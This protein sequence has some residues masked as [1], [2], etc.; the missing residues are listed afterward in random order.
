MAG[1]TVAIYDVQDYETPLRRAVDLLQQGGL[2]VLPTE[3][4]YGSAGILT[5]NPARERLKGLRNSAENKP[6]TIHVARAEDA[7]QYIAPPNE[8]AKR[9]MRKLWPGPVGIRFDVPGER[10]AEVAKNL[11]LVE[12]DLYDN[13]QITLRCPDHPV[14]EHVLHEIAGPVVITASRAALRVSE[15]GDVAEKVDFIID[16]GPTRFSKPST[17]V[18]V[19]GERYEIVRVGVYDE[20]IIERLLKTTVL[21]VC[22]GNTCRS[23][24]SEAIARKIIAER[25][26][27]A[28]EE[29][30]SKGISVISAGSFAM[31][32]TR[33]TPQAVEAL[34]EM[35]IDL[36]KHRSRPLS[37]E[38][39]HQADAIFTMSHAHAQA[40]TSLVPAAREKTHTLDPDNDIDDPIGAD[41]GVYQKLAQSL[42]PLIARRL[43]EGVLP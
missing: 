25:L 39:I 40:V 18:H 9:M 34:R 31:P 36:S 1:E 24:M 6:F 14:A 21:F 10:R 19:L 42:E 33:A 13:G 43:K 17:I 29:I 12:I 26:K 5:S 28:P 27:V 11:N 2:V 8:F 4:V 16:A 20:R 41:V 3:T 35:N 30:E 7:L 32:G 15:L 22:S 23:P 38:L 37:V